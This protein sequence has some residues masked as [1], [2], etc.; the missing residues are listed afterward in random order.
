MKM[1]KQKLKHYT[2]SSISWRRFF[3]LIGW[4]VDSVVILDLKTEQI[5][6]WYSLQEFISH[7]N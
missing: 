1:T 3:F 5:F 4:N 7:E 6:R 2:E